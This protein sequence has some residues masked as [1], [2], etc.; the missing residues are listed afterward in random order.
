M[1]QLSLKLLRVVS[2][3]GATIVRASREAKYTP[4]RS[5]RGDIEKVN[6]SSRCGRNDGLGGGIDVPAIE[7]LARKII[8]RE[9]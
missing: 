6:P 7:Q 1:G 4:E 3:V 2:G 8:L 9:E 5:G